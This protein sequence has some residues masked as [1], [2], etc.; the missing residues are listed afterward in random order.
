MP[1]IDLEGL[2]EAN[3]VLLSDIDQR[4]AKLDERESRAHSILRECAAARQEIEQDRATVL[5]IDRLYRLRF[6]PDGS[7]DFQPLSAEP[8]NVASGPDHSE[9]RPKGRA[10]I[11]P[12]RY[13]MLAFLERESRSLHGFSLSQVAD[14]TG[15]GQR[16]VRDQ[17]RS[18]SL[19]GVVQEQDGH[20]RITPQ[21]IDLLER[22]R[23]YKESKGELLPSLDGPISDDEASDGPTEPESE[24]LEE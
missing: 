20:F 15:L 7:R 17:M 1:P 13:R 5:A 8:L 16:R 10:R 2:L 12:Q 18:D 9:N 23:A 21:G 6:V 14:A 19:D 4:A 22:F 3:R 24:E 11:G